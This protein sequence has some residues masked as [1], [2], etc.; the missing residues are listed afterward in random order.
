MIKN[1]H[2]KSLGWR[3]VKIRTGM[4]GTLIDEEEE[5]EDVM[6]IPMRQEGRK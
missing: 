6:T 1:P 2:Q 3:W 5:E 4:H